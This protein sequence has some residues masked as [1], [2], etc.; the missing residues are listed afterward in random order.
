[1]VKIQT[2]TAGEKFLMALVSPAKD[3]LRRHERV[4]HKGRY[5][6]YRGTKF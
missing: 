2:Q 6:S 3:G 4:L 1:M 5:K